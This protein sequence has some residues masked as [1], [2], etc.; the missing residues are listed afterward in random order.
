M[1]EVA[2]EY[3]AAEGLVVRD[4]RLVAVAESITP[5]LHDSYGKKLK[6]LLLVSL[7]N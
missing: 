2:D 3:Q 1:E 6:A 7:L 4:L 5:P